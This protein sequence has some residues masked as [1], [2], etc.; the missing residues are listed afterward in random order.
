MYKERH[1]LFFAH[2]STAL[3]DI[4]IMTK[5]TLFYYKLKFLVEKIR[6]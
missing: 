3:K 5:V 2:L 6:K 4:A 1:G